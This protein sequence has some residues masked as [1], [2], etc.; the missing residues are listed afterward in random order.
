[1]SSIKRR[2]DGKYRARYRDS[3]GREHARHFGRKVDA[4][5]WLDEVTASVVRGDYVD[6]RAGKVTL[7]AYAAGWRQTL[8]ARPATLSIVDNALQLHI[9]PRLGSR[10]MVSLRRSDVQGLVKALCDRL[11]PGSVRN[12]YDTLSRVLSAAVHDRVIAHSPCVRIVLPAPQNS[13][14][15]PPEAADVAALAAAVPGRYRALVVLFAGTGLRIGEA[16]GLEVGDVDFLRRTVRVEASGCRTARSVR[17][18]PRKAPGR[19]RWVR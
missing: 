14:V 9:L 6:P 16:L 7:A 5:R 13:E 4:Q 8:V 10:P 2:E 11:S 18:R 3:S 1:M 19:C 15:V 12:V 17:R